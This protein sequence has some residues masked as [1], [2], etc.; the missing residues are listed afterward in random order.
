MPF[1]TPKTAV[2]ALSQRFDRFAEREFHVSPLYRLLSLGITRD[3]E[4]LVLAAH[5]CEGRPVPNWFLATVHYLL[6]KGVP[7]CPTAPSPRS[8]GARALRAG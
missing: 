5:A 4:V 3:P 2:E 8:P 7:L 6:L 1:Q